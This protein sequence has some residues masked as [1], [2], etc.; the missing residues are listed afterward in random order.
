MAATETIALIG[1]PLVGAYETL[2]SA[3]WSG[4]LYAITLTLLGM[5]YRVVVVK[6]FRKWLEDASSGPSAS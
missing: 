2:H 6:I 1:G 4:Y 5:G 3:R